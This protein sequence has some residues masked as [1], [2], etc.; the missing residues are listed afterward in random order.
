MLKV[1]A[2]LLTLATPIAACSTGGGA[3][4]AS[5]PTSPQVAR[6]SGVVV[7]VSGPCL[8]I[9]DYLQRTVRVSIARWSRSNPLD[10][11]FAEEIRAESTRLYQI[12]GVSTVAQSAVYA[13]ANSLSS[14]STSI[15]AGDEAGAADA[16]E[17]A[18]SAY[19]DIRRAC[20]F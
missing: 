7:R 1:A 14:L 16:A 11:R 4:L 2:L 12:A 8:Q 20:N 18:A 19:I 3:S 10:L 9:S 5:L 17:D 13:L 6:S 15:K